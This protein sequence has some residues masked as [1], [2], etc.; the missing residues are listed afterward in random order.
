[1]RRTPLRWPAALAALLL[2]VAAA[3]GAGAADRVTIGMQLEPPVLDP[4]SN[5]AA[6]ISEALYGNVFEGLVQ[7]APDGSVLPG[8]AESWVISADGLSY[9]FH[10]RS[11]VRFHNGA[12]FDASTAKYSLDRALAPDSLNPQRSRLQA[13]P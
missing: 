5:P 6:A 4:S 10:L 3:T 9:T 12:A 8:L 1:M 13:I 11:G 2:A 7:F